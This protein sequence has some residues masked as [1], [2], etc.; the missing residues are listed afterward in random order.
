M[1]QLEGII[2]DFLVFR[3]LAVRD[4]SKTL[5]SDDHNE[6]RGLVGKIQLYAQ[7]FR[8]ALPMV[9]VKNFIIEQVARDRNFTQHGVPNEKYSTEVSTNLLVLIYYFASQL[10]TWDLL[11]Q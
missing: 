2:T 4:G 9:K 1:A 10:Q 5:R 3:G 11:W 6:L 8:D 7:Q